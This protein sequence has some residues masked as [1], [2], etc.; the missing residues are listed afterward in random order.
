[1]VCESFGLVKVTQGKG[2]GCLAHQNFPQ[3][4]ICPQGRTEARKR[5]SEA[6]APLRGADWL[7]RPQTRGPVAWERPRGLR[8]GGTQPRGACWGG[9][10][11]RGG[12][13]ER[14]SGPALLSRVGAAIAC[15]LGE[16]RSAPLAQPGLRRHH[17]PVRHHLFQ[18]RAGLPQPHL[19][20]ELA[21]GPSPGRPLRGAGGP[22]G[23]GS[24]SRARPG[25]AALVALWWG[26]SRSRRRSG[27]CRPEGSGTR[28]C[29]HGARVTRVAT[30]GAACGTLCW[31][32]RPS[33]SGC[34]A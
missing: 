5:D 18:D 4:G 12:L 7:K 23:R 20:G 3:R 30:V 24:Q 31:L 1:M 21:G 32:P 10:R 28:A 15:S 11:R 8:A 33:L 16:R 22:G 17:G 14:G 2:G 25:P 29:W 19:L 34:Q 27:R 9:A 6:S 26:L 13:R